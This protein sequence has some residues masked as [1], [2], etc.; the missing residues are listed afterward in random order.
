MKKKVLIIL[1]SD[2]KKK[3]LIILSWAL[4]IAW[5]AVIFYFSSQTAAAS[6]KSSHL[7]SDKVLNLAVKEMHN[8]SKEATKTLLSQINSITRKMA[9]LFEY[10]MLGFLLMNAAMLYDIKCNKRIKAALSISVVYAISDE[11]HQFFSAG[12][13]PRIT[14]VLIDSAGAAIGICIFLLV[15]KKVM[16]HIKKKRSL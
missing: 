15:A 8:S 16:P 13:G 4:V 3:V 12:R 5:M 7:I 1:G 14:D 6:T 10:C 9:H 2:E 11:I